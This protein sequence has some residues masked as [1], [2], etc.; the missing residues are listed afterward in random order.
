M[1]QNRTGQLMQRAA[2]VYETFFVPALFGQWPQHMVNPD[3]VTDQGKYLDVACG[4]GV[5]ARHLA[6]LVSDPRKISAVDINENMLSVASH[7]HPQI[8]WKI[9]DVHNLPYP[10]ETFD[11][12]YC[13]FGLMFFKPLPGAIKEMLR[14]LRKQKTLTLSVWD[15]VEHSPGYA[16]VCQLLEELFGSEVAAEMRMP[17]GL[18]E[19]ERIIAAL[20]PMGADDKIEIDTV[21]GQAQFESIDNWIYTDIKGWTL[22]E[23]LSESQFQQFRQHALPRLQA[24]VN[25]RGQVRFD[26]PAHLI[27]IVKG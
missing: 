17:F 19:K 3:C 18:G 24:F 27:R 25:E 16:S 15:R 26:A 22:A 13:Q 1:S 14:V 5:L 6:T 11:A 20:P 21:V 9:A 8:G 10:E 7:I 23:V 12:V 4:T 2:E